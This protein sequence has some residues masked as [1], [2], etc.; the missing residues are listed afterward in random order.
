MFIPSVILLCQSLK[1]TK[2]TFDISKINIGN[3]IKISVAL[4]VYSIIINFIGYIISTFLLGAYTI[5]AL[6]LR[7][8][9]KIIL[10]PLAIVLITFICFKLLLSIPLPMAFLDF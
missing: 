7:D 8:M 9:K 10:Y 6:G 3:L 4:I 5:Y 1:T 2:S